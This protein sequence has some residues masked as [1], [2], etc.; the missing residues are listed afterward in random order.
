M[1]V[2]SVFKG[3]LFEVNIA[4]MQTSLLLM[5]SLNKTETPIRSV[6]SVFKDNLFDFWRLLQQESINR[7]KQIGFLQFII[8]ISIQ[9]SMHHENIPI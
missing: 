1:R 8:Y 3:N 4:A 2:F 5:K 9:R 6:F 7:Q